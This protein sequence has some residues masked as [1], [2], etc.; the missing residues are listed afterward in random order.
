MHCLAVELVEEGRLQKEHVL[1]EGVYVNVL[2]CEAVA[3]V[4]G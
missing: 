2:Q 4:A 3:K 1:M